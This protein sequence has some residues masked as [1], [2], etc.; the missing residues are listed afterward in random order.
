MYNKTKHNLYATVTV[1]LIR[2]FDLSKDRDRHDSA[3]LI[4]KETYVSSILIEI[5]EREGEEQ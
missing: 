2:R 5:Y 3:L 4:D 1:S